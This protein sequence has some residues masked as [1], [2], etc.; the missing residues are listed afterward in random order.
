MAEIRERIGPDQRQVLN[1]SQIEVL[2]KV[3]ERVCM[4]MHVLVSGDY[5]SLPEPLRWSM[6]G[7]PGTGK[8][9]VIKIIKEER[10]EKVLKW[11][12]GVE[13][14][15]IALQAVVAVFLLS[16]DTVHQAFNIPVIGTNES[17]PIAK[18]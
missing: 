5:D 13:F 11:N 10:F 14:Q 4:E 15:I 6:H 8:T 18:C 16:G 7:G 2:K 9:H 12:T 1:V 17:K 3:A